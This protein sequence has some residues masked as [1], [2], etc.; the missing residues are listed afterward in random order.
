MKEALR[1]AIDGQSRTINSN[2]IAAPMSVIIVWLARMYGLD[3]PP[4]VSAAFV[5][6]IMGGLNIAM[7]FLTSLPLAEKARKA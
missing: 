6:L 4:E 7:R 5:A 1:A 3:M 2:V